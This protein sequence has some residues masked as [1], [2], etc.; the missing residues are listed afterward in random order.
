LFFVTP[1]GELASSPLVVAEIAG[2]AAV[3]LVVVGS[4]AGS[5]TLP[6]S[7]VIPL[8]EVAGGGP[9]L[10]ALALFNLGSDTLM[11]LFDLTQSTRF[12]WALVVA[13]GTVLWAVVFTRPGRRRDELARAGLPAID[14]A[15]WLR[16]TVASLIAL[17]VLIGP[18]L[19]L[20]GSHAYVNPIPV[21]YTTAV[22][23]DVARELL[24]RRRGELVAVWPIHDPMLLEPVRAVLTREGI[25]HH[26]QATRIRALLCWWGAYAPMMVLVPG[27]R[28]AAAE[29]TIRTL[30]APDSVVED[31]FA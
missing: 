15:Q 16:A 2:V 22:I 27:D 5:L 25:P 13:A 17:L 10:A 7:G 24:A 19:V 9:V 3:T 1:W 20:R 8:Y 12:V 6:A 31:V 14:G 23:A 11:R 30:I 29:R 4:R 18:S 28:A 26:V 21:V